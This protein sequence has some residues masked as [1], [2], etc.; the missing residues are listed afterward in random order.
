MPVACAPAPGG[1]TAPANAATSTAASRRMLVSLPR[2]RGRRETGTHPG[3][4][5]SRSQK[6]TRPAHSVDGPRRTAESKANAARDDERLPPPT[7]PRASANGVSLLPFNLNVV[8]P[9]KFRPAL[10][11]ETLVP[12]DGPAD[13]C[14]MFRPPPPYG[15]KLLRAGT[16]NRYATLRLI[17]Q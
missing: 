14:A 15:R 6:A 11:S 10:V 2:F 1:R 12:P 5:R 3:G 8:P 13:A 7:S 4:H 17:S 9:S 16:V